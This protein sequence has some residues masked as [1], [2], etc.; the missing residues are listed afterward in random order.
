M[1]L[2]NRLFEYIRDEPTATNKMIEEALGTSRGV[3]STYLKRLEV[4]GFIRIKNECGAR[5]IEI[6]REKN[7]ADL[8]KEIYKQMLDVY[9]HDFE[10]ATSFAERA[11]IGKL[12]IRLLEKI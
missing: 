5:Y 6:L 11:E 1:T 10:E 4:D 3:V 2:I 7:G 12:I 8:K 9:L